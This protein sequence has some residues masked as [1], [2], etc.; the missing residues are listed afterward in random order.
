MTTVLLVFQL[1]QPRIWMSMSRDGLLPPIFSAIHPRFKTPWFSTLMTGL[2]VA[3]PALFMNLTEVTD[4]TS[5]GTFAFVLVSAGVLLLGDLATKSGRYV[6]Y[7]D[8]RWIIPTLY[9][10]GWIYV[11]AFRREMLL[12]W[13]SFTDPADPTIH[14]WAVFKHQIPLIVFLIG[15]AVL[16]LLC[17]TKRL[18]LIPVMG[19]LTC[20]Y[21]MTEL[22][23]TNWIRFGIW[24]ILGLVLYFA[25]GVRHSKLAQ[26]TAA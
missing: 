1:G 16:A 11:L 13:L 14:G 21:L 15:S 25:Y 19:V 18:S 10:G 5:I 6:K 2:L 7:V 26:R 20:G 24:L 4:L 17:F 22:G 3:V 9:V 23:L 12:R 8:S